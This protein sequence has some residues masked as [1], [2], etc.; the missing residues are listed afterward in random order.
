MDQKKRVSR[1]YV[2]F[3]CCADAPLHEHRGFVEETSDLIDH[4]CEIE[5]LLGHFPEQGITARNKGRV[6]RYKSKFYHQKRLILKDTWPDALPYTSLRK[7]R[8][9]KPPSTNFVGQVVQ[10]RFLLELMDCSTRLEFWTGLVERFRKAA[11][12]SHATYVI[13][14]T[15]GT[16]SFY[17]P[18]DAH[19]IL[20]GLVAA[21]Y[22][23]AP[24]VSPEPLDD[25]AELRLMVVREGV[26]PTPL[27]T[28]VLPRLSFDDEEYSLSREAFERF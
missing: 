2:Q 22:G 24:L 13:R 17:R 8:F 21:V 4:V 20:F 5:E 7:P 23:Q 3:A 18:D 27:K 19:T 10:A 25:R 12:F 14:W 15:D 28:P 9:A 26:A 1:Y 11:K 16:T 6:S